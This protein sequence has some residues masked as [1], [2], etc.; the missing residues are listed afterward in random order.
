MALPA[1][2]D[3]FYICIYS[4]NG[5]PEPIISVA[6]AR[7]TEAKIVIRRNLDYR[8]SIEHYPVVLLFFK[9]YASAGYWLWLDIIGNSRQNTSH[10]VY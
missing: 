8:V 1:Q 2:M 5:Y 7:L 9:Y 6:C 3:Y 10:T 4:S